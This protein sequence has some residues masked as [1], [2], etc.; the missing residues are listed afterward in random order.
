[1]TTQST[2]AFDQ[3]VAIQHGMDGALGRNVD[4]GESPDQALSDFTVTPTGVLALHVQDKVL[5]LKRKLMS[6][7]IGTTAS[8][9]QPLNAACLISIKNLVARFAGDS[10]LPAKFRHWL[11]G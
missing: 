3:A 4:T 1:M 9:C 10:E 8:V 5:H 11:A 6:I 7:A 2:A